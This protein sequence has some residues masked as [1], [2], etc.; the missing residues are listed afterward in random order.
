MLSPSKILGV[1]SLGITLLYGTPGMANERGDTPV[2][3]RPE[4]TQPTYAG[5]EEVQP[6]VAP[7]SS[8]IQPMNPTHSSRG[9]R[10]K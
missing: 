2:D 1:L 4:V 5:P 7:S 9:G 6:P 8:Y 10:D 3:R